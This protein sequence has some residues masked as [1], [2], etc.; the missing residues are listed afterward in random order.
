MTL[1]VQNNPLQTHTIK[2][3]NYIPAVPNSDLN[4][5]FERRREYS[6]GYPNQIIRATP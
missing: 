1:F 3:K 4:C 2:S 5:D 6:Q